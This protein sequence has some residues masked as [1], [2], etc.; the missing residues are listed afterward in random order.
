MTKNLAKYLGSQG[1]TNKFS[2]IKG[3]YLDIYIQQK[4]HHVFG[5]GVAGGR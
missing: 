4:V 1:P 3:L 5:H 2:F